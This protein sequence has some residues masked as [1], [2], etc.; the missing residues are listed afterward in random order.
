MGKK[1]IL[2]IEDEK[3]VLE[4][5]CILLQEEGY[6]VFEAT[7]GDSGI[8]LAK[9]NLP[10]LIICDIMMRGTDG[11]KVL[12]TLSQF[13]STKAI[14]FIFLTAKVEREDIRTGMDLGADDYL[15]KPFKSAEL[16][17]SIQ[18]RLNRVNIL[19]SRIEDESENRSTRYSIDDKIFTKIGTEPYVI[20]IKD[21]VFIAAENQYSS[22]KLING[23]TLILRRSIN[24]WEELLPDK[25]FQRIHRSTIVNFDCITKMERLENSAIKV[26]LQSTDRSFVV[27]KRYASKLRKNN[28]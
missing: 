4:N 1:K 18:A 5:I 27:S 20:K 17:K 7:T 23:K 11:Y 2:V 19:K 26:N 21:I 25:T 14:P 12:K 10:D 15:F 24:K 22:L 9:E 3:N 28:K 6:T 16:L 8:K 13:E